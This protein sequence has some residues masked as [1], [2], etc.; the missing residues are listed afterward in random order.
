MG[1]VGV[2]SA[3]GPQAMVLNPAAPAR[4]HVF[5]ATAAYAKWLLDTRQQSLFVSRS[6]RRVV[7]SA[8]AASFS[9]GRFEYREEVPTEAP[10]GLFEPVELSGY[11]NLAMP[12][13]AVA[14]GGLTARCFYSR[15]LSYQASGLGADIGCRVRPDPNVCIGVSLVD[16]GQIL[17]FRRDPIRLPTRARA[18]ASYRLRLSGWEWVGAVDASYFL[19]DPNWGVQ[20]GVETRV[21]SLL[22]LRCG[23]DVGVA[24]RGRRFDGVSFGIGMRP[25]RFFFD[26]A[27]APLRHGLGSAHR[28][29]VGIGL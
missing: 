3:D 15:I 5:A 11:V 19:Y 18:G 29:S 1:G 26:Y 6:L 17:A 12:L 20:L 23:Y 22:Q 28:F 4:T 2:A 25:G 10:L 27:Y 14:E 8:G 9:A 7:L 21:A 13:T 16:F 24:V